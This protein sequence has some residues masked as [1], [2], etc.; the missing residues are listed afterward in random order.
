M[1]TFISEFVSGSRERTTVSG[2]PCK[3]CRRYAHEGHAPG[4]KNVPTTESETTTE[5]S[6]P[7]N[8]IYE[9]KVRSTNLTRYVDEAMYESAEMDTV[10]PR[11]H[12][13][14]APADPLG[15]V[16]NVKRMY[17]G[18]MPVKSV[19][20]RKGD[21]YFADIEDD[22][23]RQAW[24]DMQQTALQ[25]PLEFVHLHF[26]VEGVTRAFT[27]QMIRQRT[28]VYAQESLRFAVV[29]DLMD[30]VQ[31]PPSI[32]I[33]P[34]D[35][36]MRREWDTTVGHI[37]DAYN[38]MVANNI[39]AEDARGLLPHAVTT[40]LHYATNLRALV[41]T[42]G[43]RSC[44]QAQFE[45]RLFVMGVCNELNK[46]SY[47][48]KLITDYLLKPVC[49]HTGKCE[50][51]ATEDRKCKIRPRVEDGRFDEIHPSEYLLDPTAAR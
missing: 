13:L 31:P 18:E 8:D 17:R 47:Q 19:L 50:F 33:L 16:A 36:P 6:D 29:H 30:R 10:Y 4:C 7:V 44:T 5:S 20:N 22:E 49:F 32:A 38:M 34:S 43:K 27:H 2:G 15:I 46:I 23:K 37:G 14:Q 1:K 35:H 26:F 12:V 51:K 21:P 24:S 28:A 41:D 9:D 42:I 25:A 11:V 40:R 39:P 45:W 3:I 48:W